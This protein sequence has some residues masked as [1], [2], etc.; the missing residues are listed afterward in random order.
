MIY[1]F[2]NKYFEWAGS[3][4]SAEKYFNKYNLVLL[5]DSLIEDKNNILFSKSLEILK[6]N[7]VSFAI[8]KE[9]NINKLRSLGAIYESKGFVK[10]FCDKP[11]KNLKKYNSFWCSFG[12]RKQSSKKLLKMMMRSIKKQEVSLQN[13]KITAK[14]FYINNYL[15]LGTWENLRSKKLL[16][17]D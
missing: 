12:F 13:E 3:V 15:D 16:K 9:K 2:N 10:S 8:K 7:D 14:A 11:Q 1:Y 17:Y 5:P 6:N 4:L